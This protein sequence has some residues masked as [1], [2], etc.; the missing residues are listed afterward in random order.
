MVPKLERRL[1]NNALS[2]LGRL[3]PSWVCYYRT[4]RTTELESAEYQRGWMNMF[5]S[6]VMLQL[7]KS[8][9][10]KTVSSHVMEDCMAQQKSAVT[11]TAVAKGDVQETTDI[12]PA[13][14]P[15]MWDGLT[16][17][18]HRCRCLNVKYL[19][20]TLKPKPDR[21]SI[22]IQQWL[23]IYIYIYI[24]YFIQLDKCIHSIQ[25]KRQLIK[26]NNITMMW[27]KEKLTVQC[28]LLNGRSSEPNLT[29]N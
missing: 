23:I 11:D 21:S 5:S 9:G 27:K 10:I 20:N 29:G 7:E 8:W 15:T 16:V 18:C 17:G 4:A 6:A 13:C 1:S 25:Y 14:H 26:T 19:N 28:H 2:L 3:W 12:H 22:M 24:L